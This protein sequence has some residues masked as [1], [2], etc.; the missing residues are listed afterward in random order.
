MFE[1]LTAAARGE[2]F[3]PTELKTPWGEVELWLSVEDLLVDPES[4]I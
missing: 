2:G 1:A 4:L 3:V